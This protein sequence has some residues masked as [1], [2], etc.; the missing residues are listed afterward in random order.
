M[1]YDAAML[2]PSMVFVVACVCHALF[3]SAGMW[4]IEGFHLAGD[5]TLA[6]L[7]GPLAYVVAVT[8][9]L[10]TFDRSTWKKAA[11]VFLV[12]SPIAFWGLLWPAARDTLCI[13]RDCY[14]PE[15]RAYQSRVLADVVQSQFAMAVVA[16]AAAACAAIS[17]V[18]PANRSVA[19]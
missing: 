4:R 18:R 15:A 3:A 5:N 13:A 1:R 8:L 17:V 9:G 6:F 12:L 16:W 19:A 2:R 14:S 11:F 7:G 10:L